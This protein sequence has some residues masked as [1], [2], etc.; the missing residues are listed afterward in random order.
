MKNNNLVSKNPVQR[1]KQGKKIIKAQGGIQ[2]WMG[3]MGDWYSGNKKEN[4][5][6]NPTQITPEKIVPQKDGRTIAKINGKWYN[7]NGQEVI[8]FSSPVSKTNNFSKTRQSVNDYANK[9][10]KSNPTEKRVITKEVSTSSP[11][12]AGY[13]IGKTGGLN[14]SISDTDKQQ[15]IGTGQFTESDFTNALATQQAL[16]RYFANSGL[17]SI[18]EDNAWGDQSRK[19]LEFALS[20]SKSLTPFSN[21]TTVAKTPVLPTYTPPT[22]PIN[23]EVANLKLNIPQ[24]TY[25]RTG[26]RELIR[27]KGIN[28]YSFSGAQRRALRMVL[29]NTA[30]DN[31]KLLVKGMGLFKKGG[32]ISKNPIER[33]KSNFR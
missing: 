25:D 7:Q 10:L 31:D 12:F 23:Q 30:D 16:N 5:Y 6:I 22:T 32:L 9:L 21:E 28:P 2:F 24:Q 18:K 15:L 19:A 20:K 17:G 3:R 14:Y 29:N 33:S 8:N 4:T 11:V 13:R 26:V 27:N 1:F